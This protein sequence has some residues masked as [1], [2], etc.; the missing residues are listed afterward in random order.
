MNVFIDTGT[1]AEHWPDLI[2]AAL[3][4]ALGIPFSI[5]AWFLRRDIADNERRHERAENKFEKVD[6]CLNQQ[7]KRISLLEYTSK[8]RWNGEQ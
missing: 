8:K 3:V 4:A 1:L 5:I 7:D 6:E 2:V